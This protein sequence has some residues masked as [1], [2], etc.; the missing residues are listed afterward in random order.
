M[1]LSGQEHF[2]IGGAS[3]RRATPERLTSD[4]LAYVAGE[5]LLLSA[6]RLL[7]RADVACV[8]IELRDGGHVSGVR[9]IRVDVP[10]ALTASRRGGHDQSIA[11]DRVIGI[12]TIMASA[13][14]LG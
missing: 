9:F 8:D 5:R 11:L 2:V 12:R 6:S 10:I 3:D 4:E 1:D 13:Q 14:G 7:Q